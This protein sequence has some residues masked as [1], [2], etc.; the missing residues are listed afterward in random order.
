MKSKRE[1]NGGGG[2]FNCIGVG[3]HYRKRQ[4]RRAKYLPI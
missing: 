1:K 4:G 3:G 2:V